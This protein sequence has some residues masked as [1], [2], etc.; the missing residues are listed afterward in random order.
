MWEQMKPSHRNEADSKKSTR[1]SNLEEFHIQK[2][3]LVEK[4]KNHS[5]KL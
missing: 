1:A 3:S 4:Y 5:V 2:L